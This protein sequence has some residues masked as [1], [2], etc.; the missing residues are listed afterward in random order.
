MGS[1]ARL[2]GLVAILS[3]TAAFVMLGF[4]LDNT[5]NYNGSMTP[6]GKSEGFPEDQVLEYGFGEDKSLM[7]ID[8]SAIG[9]VGR[10]DLKDKFHATLQ[11]YEGGQSLYKKPLDIGIE[12]KGRDSRVKLNYGFDIQEWDPDDESTDASVMNPDNWE[13]TTA[14][15][16]GDGK[17]EKW[18]LRGGFLEPT[19]TRDQ[20]AAYSAG[21]NKDG[22]RISPT[23][24]AKLHEL[25]FCTDGLCTYEGVYLLMNEGDETAIST[26]L[27]WKNE[28]KRAKKD[29]ELIDCNS[30][31]DLYRT[32]V[33]F[34]YSAQ[35]GWESPLKRDSYHKFSECGPNK[36]FPEF[37]KC[38][39]L[40]GD[41]GKVYDHSA[42][43][44]E[45][46]GNGTIDVVDIDTF[47]DHFVFEMLMSNDD[48]PFAS[49][50]YYSPPADAYTEYSGTQIDSVR[51]SSCCK[52]WESECWQ[53]TDENHD[54]SKYV[55]C[56]AGDEC[57]QE[58]DDGEDD[59]EKSGACKDCCREKIT[60]WN[61][62][63]FTDDPTE[64][65]N[66]LYPAP[67]YDYDG[68]WW[69]VYT[70]G[71]KKTRPIEFVN[72][73]YYGA[74]VAPLWE[75]L[76]RHRP[77]IEAVKKL[78]PRVDELNNQ[79]QGI[80]AERREQLDKGYWDRNN[81]RW[82]PYGNGHFIPATVKIEYLISPRMAT[83]KDTMAKELDFMSAWFAKRAES[84]KDALPS[85]KTVD[86][87]TMSTTTDVW[88][89]AAPTIALFGVTLIAAIVWGV[90]SGARCSC[91]N[92]GSYSPF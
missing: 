54:Y 68:I 88:I 75:K 18:I 28:P 47:A 32:T 20:F 14:D 62:P 33:L 81:A 59:D 8:L 26:S 91:G 86:T 66:K 92:S 57:S 11:M 83:V 71:L 34:E 29:D 12:I 10:I 43:L 15:L 6:S 48:F 50:F 44:Y 79:F 27:N 49:Q 77:F 21:T 51:P 55:S 23:Y 2:A 70:D 73:D 36:I 16:L 9:G 22:S 37:P 30:P 74:P 25:V 42:V 69:R 72:R 35:D 84:I 41:C 89:Y 46:V 58:C 60:E 56:A 85:L 19:L 7:V 90:K 61:C 31:R 78:G 63:P 1:A 38:K 13:D 3:G 53:I 82:E 65:Y 80:I 87:T 4:T 76:G 17:F 5:L 45:A 64:P 67:R 24:G 39:H 40:K 52:E